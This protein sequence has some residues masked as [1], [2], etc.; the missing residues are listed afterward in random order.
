MSPHRLRLGALPALALLLCLPSVFLLSG[1]A[2]RRAAEA[3]SPIDQQLNPADLEAIGGLGKAFAKALGDSDAAGLA[4][5]FTE[6][7][8]L[9]PVDDATCQGRKEIADYF[10][11]FLD[12]EPSTL[13]LKV[14]ET[15][16]RGDWAFQ[17]LDATRTTTDSSTGEEGEVWER[18]FWI[19]RRQPGGNWLIS[20]AIANVDE[21]DDEDEGTDFQ[22]Q[23]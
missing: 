2:C 17:W 1:L 14:R 8:V 18:Y 19:L 15:E 20:R 9:V 21:S 6:D 7:A 5:L 12:E 16:V 10:S 22:P 23:T 11:D 4:D 13:E 3:P